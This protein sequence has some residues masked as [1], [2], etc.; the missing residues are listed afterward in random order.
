MIKYNTL[1]VNI[2]TF[3]EVLEKE[4]EN[5]S[6]SDNVEYLIICL[7]KLFLTISVKLDKPNS[8]IILGK[9]KNIQKYDLI[10]RLKFKIMDITDKY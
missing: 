8:R 7:C 1:E 3:F 10:K 4:I 2:N 6:K 9:F 5:D